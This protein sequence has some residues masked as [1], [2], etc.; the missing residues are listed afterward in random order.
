MRSASRSFSFCIS[1][2]VAEGFGGS[3]LPEEARRSNWCYT[4]GKAE[5]TRTFVVKHLPHQVE[6]R[7]TLLPPR[8]RF[9]HNF[10][11]STF[12]TRAR[13]FACTFRWRCD[14]T[15][16]LECHDSAADVTIRGFH[17]DVE[18]LFGRR[19]ASVRLGKV[20]FQKGLK[21]FTEERRSDGIE[22]TK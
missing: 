19:G 7:Q 11:R 17:D 12:T 1:F 10:C 21:G 5:A 13:F 2:A 20:R 6:Q 22:S 14:Y 18:E 8:H 4:E 16:E 15:C 9:Q 3:P